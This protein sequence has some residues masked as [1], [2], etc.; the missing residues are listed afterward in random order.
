MIH[1]G[2]YFV[3][4]S[5]ETFFGLWLTITLLILGINLAAGVLGALADFGWHSVKAAR[6]RRLHAKGYR[7]AKF[8]Q[9]RKRPLYRYRHLDLPNPWTWRWDE[10]REAAQEM[11]DN[12]TSIHVRHRIER[13]LERLEAA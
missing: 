1:V 9:P 2:D 4:I 8:P 3:L 6:I 13:S 12:P 7:I 5:G 10:L 11:L